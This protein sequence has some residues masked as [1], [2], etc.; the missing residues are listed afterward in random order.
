MNEKAGEWE[1]ARERARERGSERNRFRERGC[2]EK[3]NILTRKGRRQDMAQ[4]FDSGIA[5]AAQTFDSGL[6]EAAHGEERRRREVRGGAQS[7]D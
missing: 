6:A 1:R 2:R 7:F 5:E 3:N 4:S